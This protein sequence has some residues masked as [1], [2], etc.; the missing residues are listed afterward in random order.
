[1]RD[2]L[3]LNY[4][5]Q[6]DQASTLLELCMDMAETL[7]AD[8]FVQ[9]SQ[10]LQHRRDQSEMLQQVKVPTLILCGQQDSLCPPDTDRLMHQSISGSR[11]EIIASA[12]HLPTLEQVEQTTR[13]LK[14][15]LSQ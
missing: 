9:Q 6:S 13:A 14:Y 12:G 1:M 7:G 2:E 15:W 11:L 5:A 8:T 3:K 4:L 10:A